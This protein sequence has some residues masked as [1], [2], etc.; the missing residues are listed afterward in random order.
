MAVNL[1]FNS[2]ASGS[3]KASLPE[4][5]KSASSGPCWILSLSKINENREQQKVK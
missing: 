4:G 3:G 1:F 2:C 5:I